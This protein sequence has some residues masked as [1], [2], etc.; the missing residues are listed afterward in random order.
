[1]HS[2]PLF[3]H[4]CQRVSRLFDLMAAF[5]C[6]HNVIVMLGKLGLLRDCGL[7]DGTSQ[8]YGDSRETGKRQLFCSGRAGDSAPP[9]SPTQGASAGRWDHWKVVNHGLLTQKKVEDSQTWNAVQELSRHGWH[10]L[11]DGQL[12]QRWSFMSSSSCHGIPLL[13]EG[14]RLVFQ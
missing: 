2:P 13:T 5:D 7:S 1:M 3:F 14:L 11:L 12:W 6:L 4:G 10:I 8:T 9:A